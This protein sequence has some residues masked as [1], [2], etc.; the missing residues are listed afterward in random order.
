MKSDGQRYQSLAFLAIVIVLG[1]SLFVW[2]NK[3]LASA[4]FVSTE[5]PIAV[6]GKVGCLPQKGDTKTPQTKE[7]AQGMK[8]TSGEYYAL[9]VS[10]IPEKEFQRAQKANKI[11]VQGLMVPVEALS[12]DHWHQYDIVGIIRAQMMRTVGK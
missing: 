7:C 2:L 10:G 1:I 5:E 3:K 8:S 11:N 4:Q 12:S 6:T 9:D